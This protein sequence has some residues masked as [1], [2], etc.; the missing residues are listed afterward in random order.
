LRGGINQFAYAFDNPI[1]WTDPTGTCVCVFKGS[2]GRLTVATSCKGKLP[3]WVIDEKSAP[4]SG[5]TAGTT[6]SADGFVFGGILYKIDGSTCVELDCS[7]SGITMSTCVNNFA[8][9]FGKKEPYPVP[10]GTFGGPPKEPATGAPPP[11]AK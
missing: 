5:A 1:R 8:C 11:V 2:K 10:W 9:L 6:V 3:M 7:S 4:A